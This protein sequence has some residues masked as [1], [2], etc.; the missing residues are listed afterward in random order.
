MG[1]AAGQVVPGLV[2]VLGV[3]G[4]GGPAAAVLGARLGLPIATRLGLVPLTGLGVTGLAVLAL[5]HLHLIGAWMPLGLLAAGVT[6]TIVWRRPITTL[7]GAARPA[8]RAQSRMSP[9]P[10]AA[11]ALALAIAALAALAPPFR[12]DEVEYHWPAALQWAERGSW[13]DSDFR[14]VDGFPLMEVLYTVPATWQAYGAAH[15]L[16]L[17]T[18]IG[19]GLCAAGCA[20]AQGLRGSAAVG[21]AAMAMP[22]VW[23]GAWAAYNDTAVGAFGL[24]AA[25][26]VLGARRAFATPTL[27]TAAALCTLAISIKPTG[28]GAVGVVGL[29]LLGLARR[30]GHSRHLVLRSW[31]L[32]GGTA[33]AT[34]AFWTVRRWLITGSPRDPGVFVDN[35]SADMLSRMPSTLDHVVAPVIPLVSGVMGHMEPWG[36]RTSLVVQVLILPALI[37]VLW[38]RGAVLRRAALVGLPAWAGWI[39]MSLPGI[40]T[41]FHIISWALLVVAVRSALEHF[42][43]AH[44]RLRPWAEL[45]WGLCVAAGLL[46]VSL[47]MLR[48]ISSAIIGAG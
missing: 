36:G 47:E 5:G 16:H 9:L 29:L 41:R 27:L 14:H 31:L 12:I 22:V 33:V 28:L 32:L 43:D 37:Y 7:V 10:V 20:T 1:A 30:E 24:A 2:V 39:V 40:R 18:L 42:V 23:D 44:P 34:M 25:A 46:D 21:T 15:W 19:L 6:C 3:L 8:L 26:T 17:L 38:R 48:T 13:V 11:T 45:G 35:P 4:V